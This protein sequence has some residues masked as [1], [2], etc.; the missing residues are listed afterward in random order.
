MRDKSFKSPTMFFGFMFLAP[1]SAVADFDS[2][3]DGSDG[4]FSPKVNTVVDLSL[5]PP[6]VQLR[7]PWLSCGP[8]SIEP[9]KR[10]RKRQP[11]SRL[12]ESEPLV[13]RDPKDN[14]LLTPRYL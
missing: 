2:G 13:G 9:G 6:G 12:D 4:V 8:R 3:S 11:I 1:L 14:E 10:N 7:L 5:D